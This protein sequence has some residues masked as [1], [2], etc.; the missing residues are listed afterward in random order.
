M[1]P[2]YALAPPGGAGHAIVPER[3]TRLDEL[4]EKLKISAKRKKL[5]SLVIV[6]EGNELGSAAEIA[7]KVKTQLNMFD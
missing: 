2:R 1:P 3:P 7:V 6:A 5:F 4:V